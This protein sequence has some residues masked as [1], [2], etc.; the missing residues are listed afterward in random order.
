MGTAVMPNRP[1]AQGESK[2]EDRSNRKTAPIQV[3]RQLAEMIVQI[4]AHDGKTITD[5]ISPL[6]KQWVL[7]N[8]ERVLQEGKA[9]LDQA[10]ADPQE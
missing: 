8:Y 6:I 2:P 3:E 7:T 5:T 1:K 10:R 4:A 9:R